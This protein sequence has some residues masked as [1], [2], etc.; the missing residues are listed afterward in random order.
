MQEAAR[1]G[2]PFVEPAAADPLAAQCD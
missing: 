1:S 2:T